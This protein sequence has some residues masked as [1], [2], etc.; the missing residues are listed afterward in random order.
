MRYTHTTIEY[1]E[2]RIW[3]HPRDYRDAQDGR[4]DVG[5]NDNPLT[6]AIASTM[7]RKGEMLSATIHLTDEVEVS[8]VELTIQVGDSDGRE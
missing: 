7:A 4:A 2:P 3:N 8:N 5:P 6:Q 1:A